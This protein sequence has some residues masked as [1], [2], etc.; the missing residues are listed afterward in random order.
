VARSN[1][2]A[3][4]GQQLP[5]FHNEYKKLCQR[6]DV[7]AYRALGAMTAAICFCRQGMPEDALGV[8][9]S[10]LDRYEIA[11]SSLQNLKKRWQPGLGAVPA[12]ELTHA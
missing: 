3:P 9:R 11:D 8:L 2:A 12:K 1:V 10:A 6:R 4:A 5:L 7:A